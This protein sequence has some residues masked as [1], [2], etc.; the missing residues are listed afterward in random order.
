[1]IGAVG[2][3]FTHLVYFSNLKGAGRGSMGIDNGFQKN[4][5]IRQVMGASWA[6]SRLVL[7]LGSLGSV[8]MEQKKCISKYSTFISIL[9]FSMEARMDGVG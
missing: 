7:L 9:P 5:P 6:C 4:F 2:L 8:F 3:F 1:M